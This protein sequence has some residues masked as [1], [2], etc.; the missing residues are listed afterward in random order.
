MIEGKQVKILSRLNI[1]AAIQLR[2]LKEEDLP[3]ENSF[4]SEKVWKM[5]C[6]SVTSKNDKS[7]YGWSKFCFGDK[8]DCLSYDGIRK[9]KQKL[10]KFKKDFQYSDRGGWFET[11]YYQIEEGEEEPSVIMVRCGHNSADWGWENSFL[12]IRNKEN[13][14]K[15]EQI[16]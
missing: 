2:K 5:F 12:L 14:K 15:L 8:A 16:L 3:D 1:E 11:S 9:V 7:E 10:K 4:D 6:L 13:V